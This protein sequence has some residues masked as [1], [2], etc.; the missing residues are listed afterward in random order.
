MQP[1]SSSLPGDGGGGIRGARCLSRPAP[2]PQRVL[3]CTPAPPPRSGG[4]GGGL[5]GGNERVA[6]GHGASEDTGLRGRSGLWR[7]QVE[8][9]YVDK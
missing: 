9:G 2:P 6:R 8:G 5:P 1:T 3:R 4:G 7:W